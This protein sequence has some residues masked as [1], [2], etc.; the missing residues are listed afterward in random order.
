MNLSENYMISLH[1]WREKWRSYLMI[2]DIITLIIAEA[3]AWPDSTL[4]QGLNEVKAYLNI[5][6]EWKIA[7]IEKVQEMQISDDDKENIIKLILQAPQ[8]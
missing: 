5:V 1:D 7:D 2:E 6:I 3:K 4:L 8:A